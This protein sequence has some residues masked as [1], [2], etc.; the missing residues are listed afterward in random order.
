[1]RNHDLRHGAAS[2]MAA[3]GIPPRVA[4]ELLGHSN[5]ATTM[6]I[7]TH[8]TPQWHREAMELVS[9]ELWTDVE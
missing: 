9:K 5:I 8:T 2:I 4:M 3:L 6:D 1:M 7:Y